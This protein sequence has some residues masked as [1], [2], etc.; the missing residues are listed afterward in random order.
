MIP[1]MKAGKGAAWKVFP[2][3]SSVMTPVW[4]STETVSPGW[5]AWAAYGHSRMGKPM[6]MAL[7]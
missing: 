3:V 2:W 1:L 7:R 4:K 5:M 6:L